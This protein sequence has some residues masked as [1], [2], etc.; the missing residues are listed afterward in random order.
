[1]QERIG[2]EG[3]RDLVETGKG[4]QGKGMGQIT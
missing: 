4:G 3:E 2:H 1:M